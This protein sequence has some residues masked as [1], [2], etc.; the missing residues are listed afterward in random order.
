[1]G[2]DSCSNGCGFK[3]GHCILDGYDIFSH[4]FVVKIVL[5]VWK[6]LKKQKE[7]GVAHLKKLTILLSFLFKFYF[8][9]IVQTFLK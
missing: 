9:K 3:S 2:D 8:P 7:V 5:F 6:D 1:M 4:I